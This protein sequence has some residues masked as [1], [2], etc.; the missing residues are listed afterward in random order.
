MVN[1]LE[2]KIKI[3]ITNWTPQG[4]EVKGWGPVTPPQS[5]I[6][7]TGG[8]HGEKGRLVAR[9]TVRTA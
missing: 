3:T 4:L 8:K 1:Y 9:G 2:I 5:N 6:C 7:R